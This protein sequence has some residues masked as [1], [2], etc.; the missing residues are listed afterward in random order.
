MVG[1]DCPNMSMNPGATTM[2][3]ASIVGFAGAPAR[4]PMAAILPCRTPMS[5]E[6]HGEPVPSMIRRCCGSA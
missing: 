2:P 1:S 5:P 6:Y 3:C 4:L